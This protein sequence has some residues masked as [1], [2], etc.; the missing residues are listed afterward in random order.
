MYICILSLLQSI[1]KPEVKTIITKTS[2]PTPQ[3]KQR[4]NCLKV[5]TLSLL[6]HTGIVQDTLEEQG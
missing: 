6:N 3:W 1:S 2:F 4:L 5:T